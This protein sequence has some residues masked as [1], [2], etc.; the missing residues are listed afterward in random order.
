M[1]RIP[2]TPRRLCPGHCLRL[3]I[4][5]ALLLPAL[6]TP[7]A[8]QAVLNENGIVLRVNDEIATQWD[9]QSRLAERRRLI[10]AAPEFDAEERSRRSSEAP[11]VVLSNIFDELLITS[12]ADQL[13]IVIT[14]FEIDEAIRQMREQN[15]I[16]DDR[17][18]LQALAQEGLTLERLRDQYR[19]QQMRNGVIQREI[20]GRVDLD[21]DDLRR[22][23]RENPEE[24]RTAER[25]QVREIVVLEATGTRL[26]ADEVR[27]ELVGGKSLLEVKEQF[28]DELSNVLEV[29]W[30]ESGD[31]DPTLEAAAWDLEVNEYTQPVEAR[32]GWHIAQVT[33]REL[34]SVKP[35]ED[36]RDVLE[37]REFA[38]LMGEAY[39]DYVAELE[40]RAFVE[41]DQSVAGQ[42]CADKLAG[43]R[44]PG[45]DGDSL[46]LED[47]DRLFSPANQSDGTASTGDDSS[48]D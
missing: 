29:G 3:A 10:E 40:E 46:G 19:R 24:F 30:V 45:A 38:R 47:V 9:F 42:F 33:G 4:L 34:P 41:C 28:G 35:F 11:S 17:T 32:G 15:G 48:G 14:D 22:I 6:T 16:Q 21:E 44:T 20:R 23:Y 7:V 36:V 8:G 18:F 2:N 37:R 27:R 43:R 26:L 13:G 1:N 25:V 5:C 31:L 39:T 12:R